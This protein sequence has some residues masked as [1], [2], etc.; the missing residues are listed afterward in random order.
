MAQRGE[1]PDFIEALARGLEVIR[2]FHADRPRLTLTAVAEAAGLARP[3]ARRI[4]LTLEELGYVRMTE[5]GYELTA[6]VLELGMAYIGA[7]SLWELA[8]PHM[9]EL[10]AAT[11]ESSSISQLDGPDIVYMARVAVPKIIALRVEIGTRFPAAVTSQGKVLLAALAP[12]RLDEVL[13][14]TSRSG[15]R[16]WVSPGRSELDAALREVNARGWALADNELA[17]GIRSVAVPIRDGRGEVR[18]AMNVTVNSAETSMKVLTEQ[19]LPHL[20]RAASAISSDWA[21]W[22]SR[23]QQDLTRAAGEPSRL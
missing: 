4:L 16:P 2:T 11:G 13:A 9:S 14:M 6:R 21:L 15:V 23:P 8:R 20:L 1:G 7:Q 17:P 19:H 18:A 10:V 22:Q 3:T 5:G 12:A